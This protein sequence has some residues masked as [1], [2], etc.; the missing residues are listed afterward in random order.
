MYE[1]RQTKEASHM[2]SCTMITNES[3]SCDSASPECDLQHI[4]VPTVVHDLK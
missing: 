1:G 2:T 3:W 4:I